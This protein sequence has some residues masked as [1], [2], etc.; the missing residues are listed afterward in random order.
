MNLA[1]IKFGDVPAARADEVRGAD[2]ATLDRW[3]DALI[4]AGTLEEV[5]NARRHH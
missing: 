1:R 5:F 2:A 4:G 3:L